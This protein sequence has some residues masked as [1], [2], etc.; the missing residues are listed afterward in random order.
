MHDIRSL[1]IFMCQVTVHTEFEFEG[2]KI[3]TYHGREENGR[4]GESRKG[5]KRK[6]T[7]GIDNR[8]ISYLIILWDG[9]QI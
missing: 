7:E 2:Q 6:N 8:F 5:Y 9:S 1:V 3:K 4:H